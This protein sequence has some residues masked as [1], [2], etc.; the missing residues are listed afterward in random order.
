[1]QRAQTIDAARGVKEHNFQPKVLEQNGDGGPF[2]ESL[3][4]LLSAFHVI[5]VRA[6]AKSFNDA[7][8]YGRHAELFFFLLQTMRHVTDSTEPGGHVSTERAIFF[9]PFTSLADMRLPARN[10]PLCQGAPDELPWL[11]ERPQ[12]PRGRPRALDA[13]R[14]CA[15]GPALWTLWSCVH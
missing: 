4:P 5:R 6:A 11:C 7:K 9:G 13:R 10:D 2:W 14:A 1:M 3:W 15:Q 12:W 8:K